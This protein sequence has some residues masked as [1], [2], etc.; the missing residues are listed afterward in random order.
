MSEA[1]EFNEKDLIRGAKRGNN[2]DFGKLYDQF[3]PQIYR[4]VYLKVM[5]RQDA[6]DICHHVFMS[7]W[8]NMRNYRDIGYSFSTWLYRIARNAVIDFY[9]TKKVNVELASVEDVLSD[10]VDLASQLGA[11]L[12]TERVL[13]ALPRLTEEQRDIII[14]RFVEELDPGEIAEI[15]EK[16]TGAVRVLQHRAVHSLKKIL[17]EDSDQTHTV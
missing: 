5:N 2:R 11:T 1:Q 13:A 6:E 16:N 4:F 10:G 15:M 17:S 7:A 12:A 14:M 9:R 3:L 8:T